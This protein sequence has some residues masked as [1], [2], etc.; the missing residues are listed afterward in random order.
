M[1]TNTATIMIAAGTGPAFIMAS[2][3]ITNGN[4]TIGT[5][6]TITTETAVTATAEDIMEENTMAAVTMG[7]ATAA[8]TRNGSFLLIFEEKL[9]LRENVLR[10]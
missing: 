6:A 4:I 2:G 8:I 9:A 5:E 7:A 1:M 10:F 3:S